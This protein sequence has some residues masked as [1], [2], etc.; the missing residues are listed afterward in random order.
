MPLAPA[1]A[2]GVA[3]GV[4]TLLPLVD[5]VPA[6]AAECRRHREEPQITAAVE[7]W[8]SA[9]GLSDE[10]THAARFG[11]MAAR[12]FPETP[13]RDVVLFGEWL[14]WLFA[15][16]DLRD[17]GP[18]GHD[19]DAVDRLYRDVEAVC[20]KGTPRGAH[21]VV[22]AFGDLWRRTAAQAGPSW[23]ATFRHHLDDHRRACITEARHRT[24]HKVPSIRDYTRLRRQANGSFMFDL[25]EPVL[26][27]D[28]PGGLRTTPAWRRLFAACNDVTA[29]CND[30]A[31]ARKEQAL[32][33]VHNF[34]LVVAYERNVDLPTAA[35]YVLELIVERMGDLQTAAR[36]LPAEFRRLEMTK[37]Q[38]RDAS[39]VAVTLLGAPR[40]HLEWLLESGRYT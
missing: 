17:D 1:P 15:F 7:A 27:A 2:V 28:V 40:G 8:L 39:R 37:V 38:S 36:A 16:D 10:R 26:R 4:D 25:A 31:S 18:L 24:L 12:A 23:R 5:K 32:G 14:A 30:I 22:A 34:V 13:T 3:V 20:D 29:W 35:A 19:P 11:G 9:I 6:L 33:D 21:P